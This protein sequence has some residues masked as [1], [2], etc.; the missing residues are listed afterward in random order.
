[1]FRDGLPGFNAG[2]EEANGDTQAEKKL[3]CATVLHF[4]QSEFARFEQE[5]ARW[6]QESSVL[7]ARIAFLEGQ[8]M[9]ETNLK[10]D[11]LRRIKMLE[12]VIRQERADRAGEDTSSTKAPFTQAQSSAKV[13]E[14]PYLHRQHSAGGKKIKEGRQILCQYLSEM[15]YT[16]TV[17][18]SQ[19]QRLKASFDSWPPMVTVQISNPPNTQEE[20]HFD[21]ENDDEKEEDAPD[22]GVFDFLDDVDTEKGQDEFEMSGPVKS[23]PLG[24]MAIESVEETDQE[25]P[26]ELPIVP[27]RKMRPPPLPH[28]S[29][30]DELDPSLVEQIG[31]AGKKLLQRQSR[32]RGKSKKR[33]QTDS[34]FAEE[35]KAEEKEENL[36]ELFDLDVNTTS[37]TD[38]G[39]AAEEFQRENVMRKTWKPAVELRGHYEGTRSLAFHKTQMRLATA[40]EDM[41]VKVWNLDEPKQNKGL[42]YVDLAHTFRGHTA[43]VFSVALSTN[44]YVYSGDASGKLGYWKMPG[45]NQSRV[46]EFNR[47]QA[48]P[49]DAHTDC[50]WGLDVHQ[51]D[52]LLLSAGSDGFC[53]LWDITNMK[54]EETKAINLEIGALSCGE[55]VS[56]N[57]GQLVL[58]STGGVAHVVDLETGKSIL[59]IQDESGASINSVRVH[60]T[61]PIIAIAD[62]NKHVTLYDRSSGSQIHQMVAHQN[63]VSALS[64]DPSGLYMVTCGHD[65]SIRMWDLGDRRCVNEITT[66]HEHRDEAIHD[67]QFHPTLPYFATCGADSLV[68]IFA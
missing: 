7:K 2:K 60:H 58:G 20:Q 55:F 44:E 51:N 37:S 47:L 10:R 39:D 12:H 15:G 52:N 6:Q 41:T 26:E 42:K 18:H 28:T 35:E 25:M 32:S 40:S 16:D 45:V 4:L 19:A 54:P 46:A 9:G 8:R 5:R 30:L 64:F 65:R 22:T 11:L 68:K 62:E 59:S 49:F 38:K 1:M 31:F 53:R 13:N 50:I 36:N 24:S 17:I 43:S 56:T 14:E 67:V 61:L 3:S 29:D 63:A 57:T 23:K 21:L 48:A 27:P 66:H 33:A 34:L